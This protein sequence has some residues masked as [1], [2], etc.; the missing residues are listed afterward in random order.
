MD[1]IYSLC[2]NKYFLNINQYDNWFCSA[3]YLQILSMAR[4]YSTHLCVIGVTIA[5]IAI[6]SITGKSAVSITGKSASKQLLVYSASLDSQLH[7][8]FC[9]D[10]SL[11]FA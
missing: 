4:P 8:A 3:G 10:Q 1:F 5:F 2:A 6:N 7:E 9:P 11:Y